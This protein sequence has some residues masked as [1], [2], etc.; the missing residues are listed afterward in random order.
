MY[1]FLIAA[2]HDITFSK[3]LPRFQGIWQHVENH[4]PNWPGLRPERRS[5][6]MRNG[7]LLQSVWQRNA[8]SECLMTLQRRNRMDG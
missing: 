2:R 5:E 1:R 3:P 6:R 7:F 8:T 4:A